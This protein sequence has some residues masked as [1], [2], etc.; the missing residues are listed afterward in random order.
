MRAVTAKW[1]AT[2]LGSHV[3]YTTATVLD[4]GTEVVTLNVLSGTVT[5][6]RLAA[7]R[8]RCDIEV[9]TT[10]PTSTADDLI[11]TLATDPLTP[12]GFEIAVRRGVLYPDGTTETVGLGVFGIQ[13][14]TVE[15]PG[16]TARIVGL[17]RAQRV[18]D[19]R[20]TDNFYVPSGETYEEAIQAV[21]EGQF[22]DDDS[23]AGDGVTG[24]SFDFVTT[25]HTTPA[26]AFDG[27]LDRWEQVQTMAR[28][29][30]CDLFFDGDGVCVMR[31]EPSPTASQVVATIVDGETGTLTE[32]AV[33]LDRSPSHN[34]VIATG[35]NASNGAVYRGEAFDNDPASPTYVAGRFGSKPLFY[36]SPF[37]TSN[38]QAQLAAE[39][40]LLRE[41]GIARQL[42]L[43]FAP[44]PALEPGDVVQVNRDRVGL[45]DEIHVLETVTVALGAEGGMSA[46]TRSQ[47]VL[48][49]GS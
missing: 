3:T 35:E 6:D 12:Y 24:L 43:G 29:V 1:A 23:F 10:D 34:W 48:E 15:E 16:L 20:F 44:N 32:V 4:Q 46:T 38:A 21:I 11:P 22:L 47:Q 19:A 30:G 41:L 40:R 18:I 8:A 26:L 39:A 2:I 27:E 25:G 49:V 45:V 36:Q 9:A 7:V 31:P 37:F 14:V 17:D 28:D 13:Q 5:L 33:D 42:I